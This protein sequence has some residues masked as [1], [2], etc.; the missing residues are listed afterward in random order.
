MSE[1]KFNL[2]D[3][4]I[5]GKR[6]G[7]IGKTPAFALHGWLD[8]CASFDFL[9]PL[10]SDLDLMAVDLA[11]HG[12]SDH[13]PHG[14]AYNIW[15]DIKELIAIADQL[16]WQKF[17]LIGHS[18]GAMI[19]TLLAGTFPERVTHVAVVEAF[20]PQIVE[21][22]DAPEQLSAAITSLLNMRGKGRTNFDSF[23]AAVKAREQG[24][25]KLDHADALVLAKRGVLAKE[26]KFFWNNDIKLNAPSE[27]KFT[28][29][30]VRAFVDRIDKPVELVVADDGLVH[31]FPAMKE[32][33]E[34]TPNLCVTQLP[35]EH[36]L[37]MSHQ[38]QEVAKVFNAYF[39]S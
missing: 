5:R 3:V 36:H 31:E 24:L 13:R 14:G 11:G 6:W 4:T 28:A 9:A 7:E 38:C 16:G 33:M 10:L 22:R 17:G 27:V 1:W 30:Q 12:K 18:R 32:F 21:P 29:E 20:A 2:G 35:G 39:S 34:Q 37:H 25:L 8:N 26:G 19:A 23:E 15:L